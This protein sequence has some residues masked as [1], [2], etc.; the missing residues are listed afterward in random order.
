[1]VGEG[2]SPKTPGETYTLALEG[3]TWAVVRHHY[4]ELMPTILSKGKQHLETTLLWILK[5]YSLQTQR[6]YLSFTS[7]LY[8]S[9]SMQEILVS[10]F[11][12]L[13][14]H[15]G[16][17]HEALTWRSPVHST[18]WHYERVYNKNVQSEWKKKKNFLYQWLNTGD[19]PHLV[20][21]EQAKSL[22]DSLL[23]KATLRR[24]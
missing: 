2:G 11:L 18:P 13:V 5:V 22:H 23:W 9:A 12:C 24:R 16:W 20:R 6:H 14:K 10:I 4:P 7:Y 17:K 15:I 3:R 19:S 1:M 8:A 21:T